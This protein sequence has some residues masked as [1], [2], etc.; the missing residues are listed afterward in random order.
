VR[1]TVL[2]APALAS[3][4]ALAG[5]GTAEEQRPRL[6][7]RAAEPQRAELGWRERYPSTGLARLVFQ[8]DSLE[9]TRGG[10]SANIALTNETEVPFDA[11][12][13]TADSRYGLMLFATGDLAELE[14][15]ASSSGLPPAREA[16]EIEPEPPQSLAPGATWRARISAPGS[17]VAGSYVRVVFGP[18]ATEGELPEGMESV[19][20]W[21]TDRS[22][23][24]RG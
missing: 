21:I 12:P 24:L 5:C 9:V 6:A 2:L 15:A 20:V 8:V 16:A 4:L 22:Y 23:R 3:I 18:L 17:L 7:A 11:R 14:E 1:R 19:V 13:G 10:W